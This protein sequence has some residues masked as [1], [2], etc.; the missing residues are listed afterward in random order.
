M[1]A[2]ELKSNKNKIV[3]GP[4][5]LIPQIYKDQRG[6]F[7]ESWNQEKFNSIVGDDIIFLQDNHSQSFKGVLRGLHYQINPYSQGKLIRS[8]LGSIFDVIVDLRENSSTYGE[9][10][11]VELNSTEHN[12]LWIPA[13]FA[14]GFLSISEIVYVQYKTTSYW[15]SDFERSLLWNDQLININW[16]LEKINISYPFLSKKDSLAMTFKD[17]EGKGDI[18]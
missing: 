16:P 15:K 8:P 17:L 18:F 9:W 4:L 1:I 12:Q 10:I 11:G 14:H 5:L 6:L 7:F 3:N 2:Q 13:G